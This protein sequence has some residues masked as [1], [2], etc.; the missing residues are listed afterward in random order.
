MKCIPITNYMLSYICLSIRQN[1]LETSYYTSIEETSHQSF[2]FFLFYIIH[3]NL[4]SVRWKWQFKAI[5]HPNCIDDTAIVLSN[6]VLVSFKVTVW[7]CLFLRTVYSKMHI[8]IQFLTPQPTA[9]MDACHIARL[10]VN[11]RPTLITVADYNFLYRQIKYKKKHRTSFLFGIMML[12]IFVV[13][14]L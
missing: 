3:S 1:R 13:C 9:N 4:L 11:Y 8:D 2:F 7:R 14:F 12:S 10:V 6:I 5:I